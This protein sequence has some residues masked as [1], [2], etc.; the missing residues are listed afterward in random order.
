MSC[1]QTFSYDIKLFI[2]IIYAT[3]YY[4]PAPGD[5]APDEVMPAV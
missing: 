5:A 1:S 2:T 3:Q 4:V